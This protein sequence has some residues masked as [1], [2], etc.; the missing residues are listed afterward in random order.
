MASNIVKLR[1]YEYSIDWSYEREVE[2]NLDE[3][4]FFECDYRLGSWHLIGHKCDKG[5]YKWEAKELSIHWCYLM[6]IAEFI[7]KANKYMQEKTNGSQSCKVSRFN[8]LHYEGN[9]YKELQRLFNAV[10]KI[11]EADKKESENCLEME[12]YE[13][14]RNTCN[15]KG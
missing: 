2:I 10:A 8:S 7:Y 13:R 11:E 15:G 3:Y 6:D 4:S 12:C 9:F 5:T 1:T 14:R